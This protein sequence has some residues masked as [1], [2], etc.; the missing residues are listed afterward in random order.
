MVLDIGET[1]VSEGFEHFLARLTC[2]F[3]SA[4]PDW[5]KVDNG[6]GELLWLDWLNGHDGRVV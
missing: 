1:D 6:D 5:L 3:R 2:L 4:F